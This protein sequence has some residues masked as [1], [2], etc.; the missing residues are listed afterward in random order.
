MRKTTVL[1]LLIFIVSFFITGIS[2]ADRKSDVELLPNV[3]LTV[4]EN[5][6]YIQ[7]LGLKG[8][9][10]TAFMLSDIDADILIIELFSMYCPHC[11]KAAPAVNELYQKMEEMKRA[12]LKLV[13]IGIGASNTDLE[14]DTFRKGFDIAFPLF[15]DQDLSIYHT[16]AGKG[17]PTFIGCKKDGNKC[18]I[19]FRKSGGF[20][21]PP[22][23]LNNLLNRSGLK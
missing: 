18:V 9:P 13:I 21:D 7:Y 4:P 11:Q 5:K 2:I 10:G 22:D 23:F 15:S 20:T 16:L 6:E 19:F 17:T 12:D 1:T 8:E 3:T 14:V